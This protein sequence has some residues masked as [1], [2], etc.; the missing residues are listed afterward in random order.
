VV[1][2]AETDAKNI[3]VDVRDGKVLKGRVHSW[4]EK[5]EAKRQA[6]LA[7]GVREVVRAGNRRLEVAEETDDLRLRVLASRCRCVNQSDPCKLSARRAAE[8]AQG[9]GDSRG[10]WGGEDPPVLD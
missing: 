4:Y 10:K 6:W 8:A 3:Q 1:R 9:G 5:E 7:P 2:T